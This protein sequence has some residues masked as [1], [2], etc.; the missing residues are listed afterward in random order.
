MCTSHL[1][2]PLEATAH[3]KAVCRAIVAEA[4]ELSSFLE[5]ISQDRS[6]SDFLTAILYSSIEI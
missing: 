5:K 6:V 2:S 4:Q 1:A 3:Y